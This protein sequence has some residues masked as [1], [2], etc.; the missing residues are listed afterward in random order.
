MPQ[1]KDQKVKQF[2]LGAWQSLE[3]NPHGAINR[4]AFMSTVNILLSSLALQVAIMSWMSESGE[5]M[6]VGELRLASG[7]TT[8][9]LRPGSSVGSLLPL[10]FHTAPMMMTMHRKAVKEKNSSA[11]SHS[12]QLRVSAANGSHGFSVQAFSHSFRN[13]V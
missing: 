11:G 2:P 13:F 1:Q 7:R 10:V 9:L 6:D 5:L 4:S 8:S 3:W 12:T